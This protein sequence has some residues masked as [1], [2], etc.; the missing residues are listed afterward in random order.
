MTYVLLSLIVLL[1]IA[2]ATA[3]V[4]KYLPIRPLA[5]TLLVLV[6]LTAIFDNIIVGVGLV[7]YD[8]ELISGVR[9]PYAPIEDF[10]Y[11]VGA[12]LLI[13][14]LWVLL[15]GKPS[16]SSGIPVRGSKK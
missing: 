12:V 13:P 14:A 3:P 8:P 1:I 11:T 2:I 7:D 10:S 9:V 5:W 16:P 6:V 4:T 15:G